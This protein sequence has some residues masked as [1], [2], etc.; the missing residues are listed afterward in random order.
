L[1]SVLDWLDTDFF[2]PGE[3]GALSDIKRSLLDW[4]DEYLCLADYDSYC[5]AHAQIDVIYR[6]KALWA[7]KAVLNSAA[8]GKFNS[9]RSIEDYAST[10]WKLTKH[11]LK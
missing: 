9:D 2:T 10:I 1:K 3:A 11:P 8:M 6:N 4:G 5:E 7:E